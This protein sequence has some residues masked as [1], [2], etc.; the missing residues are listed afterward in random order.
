MK[1]LRTK[2]LAFRYSQELG[3]TFYV[4]RNSIDVDKFDYIAR[5]CINTGLRS[6]FDSS[7][8]GFD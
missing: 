7:R 4:I 3:L 6:G 8:Y 5:D 1:S 2:G